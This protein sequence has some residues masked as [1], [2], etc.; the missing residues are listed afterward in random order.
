MIRFKRF[1]AKSLAVHAIHSTCNAQT[2]NVNYCV[3]RLKHICMCIFYDGGGAADCSLS[4]AGFFDSVPHR[5]GSNIGWSVH[6]IIWWRRFLTLIQQQ[7]YYIAYVLQFI[8]QQVL[9]WNHTWMK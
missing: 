4:V 2:L 5:P 3:I 6:S 7:I 1:T 8:W 9:I